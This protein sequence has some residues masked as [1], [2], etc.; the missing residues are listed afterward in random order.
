V[1]STPTGAECE[2]FQD[3]LA[4]LAMGGLTGHDRA[5]TLAHLEGCPR[6]TARLEELSAAVDALTTLIPEATPPEGFAERTVAQFRSERT[7]ARPWA[8]RVVAVAA[9]VV[10]LALGAG[11]GEWVA[12]SQGNAP[13]TAF[14]A[15]PLRSAQGTEGSVVLVSTGN[16]G[17]LWMTVHDA[18]NSGTVTCSV[19]LTDGSR[20]EVGRFSLAGGYGEWTA[21]LPFAVTSVRAVT[22]LDQAGT[23]VAVARVT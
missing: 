23:R 20:R 17:W 3:D 22:L 8:R 14:R 13:A 12:T 19:L 5:R 21:T 11:V 4:V 9:V 1:E 2:A 7:T 15:V 16:R 10:T 18:P 6:C